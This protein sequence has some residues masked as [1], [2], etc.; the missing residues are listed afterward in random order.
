MADVAGSVNEDIALINRT[1]TEI[2]EALVS[3][4]DRLKK[5]EDRLGG[6]A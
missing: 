5:L 4:S 1:I 2:L 6:K 3:M